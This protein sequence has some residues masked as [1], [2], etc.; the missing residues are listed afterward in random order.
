ME[1]T[2]RI[3]TDVN[4]DKVVEVNLTQDVDTFEILSLKLNQKD[5]Y[6]L[7]SSNYGIVVGR[8]LA[9]GGFGIP[10][11]KISIFVELS[12]EDKMDQV[13][14]TLYPYAS[15]MS[16]DSNGRRYNLLPD[17]STDECYQV[18][19]TFPNKRLVL[20]N[21]DILEV[22]DK[23]WKY[24]TV[25]NHAGDYMIFGVPT[26]SQ[27]LHVDLDMSDI[28]ILSQSPRDFMLRGY[29]RR[30][31]ENPSQF[32]YSTNIDALPQ[33]FSQNQSIHVYPFWGDETEDVIAITR[34]DIEIDYT[35]ETSCVFM[36][37]VLTD[38]TKNDIGDK[39]SPSK[40]AGENRQLVAATGT[41]EMIRKTIGGH[42]EQIQVQ[43]DD[44]IDE[45]GV[46][47]YQI[48]MNLD[49]VMT[50]E[51]GSLVP[52]DNPNIGIATRASVRFRFT[53]DAVEDDGISRHR[54]RYLV[55]NN[56]EIIPNKEIPMIENPSELDDYYKFGQD[57]PDN[58]FRDLYW[59]KVYTVKNYI[60]RIQNNRKVNTSNYSALRLTN[61]SEDRNPIPF[62]KLR[63]N[64]SFR[65]RVI[66]AIM[67]IVIKAVGFLNKVLSKMDKIRLVRV[68]KCV[69]LTDGF[70]ESFDDGR[71][72]TYIPGCDCDRSIGRRT[73]CA[74]DD[75]TKN[76]STDDLLDSI[77]QRLAEEYELANL[78]FYNDWLNGS[79]YMPLWFWKRKKHYTYLFGLFG[80]HS[81]DRFC[82]CNNR[83]GKLRVMFPCGLPLDR[84]MRYNGDLKEG[85]YHNDSKYTTQLFIYH[86]II[87]EVEN[88]DGVKFYYYTHGNIRN[89]QPN[90]SVKT[91][92]QFVR[93][94]ATDIVLLG[95]LNSCDLDGIPQM[96]RALP[97]STAN[98]PPI[99][100]IFEEI[101]P[102][103]PDEAGNS[104]GDVDPKQMIPPEEGIVHETG[105]DWT[106][107]SE[108][109]DDPSGIAYVKGTIFDLACSHANTL[110]KTCVNVERMCELDVSRDEMY[111]FTDRNGDV[112]WSVADGMLT[113]YEIDKND[114]RVMFATLNHYGFNPVDNDGK[115]NQITRE[116][117]VRTGYYHPRFKFLNPQNF[118]GRLS[119]AAPQ[120]TRFAE[121]GKITYDYPDEDYITFRFG[122]D[123]EKHFY[124][125]GGQRK[126]P[127][128]NNSFYFYFGLEPGSTAIDKFNHLFFSPCEQRE[129]RMFT[130]NIEVEKAK[131]C[132]LNSETDYGHISVNLKNVLMPYS[133][134]LIKGGT[135]LL[136]ESGI[137]IETLQFGQHVHEGGM[138]YDN[139]RWGKLQRFTDGTETDYFLT[140]GL[141]TLILTDSA[142]NELV[143]T[144]V[145]EESSVGAAIESQSLGYEYTSGQ[146]Q[147]GICSKSASAYKCGSI[148]LK[149]VII[150]DTNYNIL[151]AEPER[152]ITSATSYSLGLTIDGENTTEQA[153]L[154]LYT[155]DSGGI[156][157]DISEYVCS[158]D[159]AD[160][161]SD[162]VMRFNFWKP[163][164]VNV[165]IMQECDGKWV[166]GTEFASIISIEN[167]KN[168]KALLNDMPYEFLNPSGFTYT[169][170]FQ[171]PKYHDPGWSGYISGDTAE[172]W[173]Q[174]TI[175][176]SGSTYYLDAMK[177]KLKA[178]F[179]M[180]DAGYLSDGASNSF[181]ISAQGGKKPILRRGVYPDYVGM[182]TIL[183]ASDGI[184]W[185]QNSPITSSITPDY[186]ADSVGYAVNDGSLA[187]IVSEEN[188][189]LDLHSFNYPPYFYDN[190]VSIAYRKNNF[191]MDG[192]RFA[193]FTNN[194]G[195]EREGTGCTL[196]AGCEAIPSSADQNPLSDGRGLCFGRVN[197]LP[198]IPYKASNYINTYFVDKRFDYV[199]VVYTPM[200]VREP[201]TA[202]TRGRIYLDI[203][204]GI[205]MAMDESG[206]IIDE[207]SQPTGNSAD[208]EHEYSVSSTSA[209]TVTWNENAKRRYY[210]TTLSLDGSSET[211]NPYD[212]S[213]ALIRGVKPDSSGTVSGGLADIGVSRYSGYNT[214]DTISGSCYLGE[215]TRAGATTGT[216]YWLNT[217]SQT[218]YP[219]R[220][221]LDLIGI[222][223]ASSYTFSNTSFGYDISVESDGN[224][225]YA[226]G[227]PGETVSFSVDNTNPI[228]FG[229]VSVGADGN[230]NF[231]RN[232][233]DFVFSAQTNLVFGSSIQCKFSHIGDDSGSTVSFE[234][235]DDA[236]NTTHNVMTRAP[237]V[238]NLIKDGD[239]KFDA[240]GE[241]KSESPRKIDRTNKYLTGGIQRIYNALGGTAMIVND[242]KTEDLEYVNM[243]D[244]SADG[245]RDP[246]NRYEEVGVELV[247]GDLGFN[248]YWGY[249]C[250]QDVGATSANQQRNIYSSVDDVESAANE[251]FKLKENAI[252]S[253]KLVCISVVR[254]YYHT[255]E[256]L[257]N[258]RLQVWN[259]NGIYDT[260]PFYIKAQTSGENEC[261]A[262]NLIPD[263]NIMFTAENTVA[264]FVFTSGT[265]TISVASDASSEGTNEIKFTLTEP[266][267]ITTS[268]GET[269]GTAV[270]IYLTVNNTIYFISAKF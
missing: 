46:W 238:L 86:G 139:Y 243:N 7:H 83:Y 207:A 111:P 28:G 254:D 73:D 78:D 39:C 63:V 178:L 91:P 45:H 128:Y 90:E 119:N 183:N 6:R 93:L 12:E 171:V 13:I 96:F 36:G 58:C 169:A 24:T 165:R 255:S 38:S 157:S 137:N 117:D 9:N 148:V 1:K 201:S 149:S 44:L 144:I 10:N 59:N 113:R 182:S 121:N 89:P 120:Y 217:P 136:D 92:S 82:S 206:R 53:V 32:K 156:P 81:V 160:V 244:F 34:A 124:P 188:Y 220:K 67:E 50:D 221:A 176:N 145:L 23:Y 122:P 167:G 54:A 4:K 208:S 211:G 21:D 99:A 226:K 129:E 70:F 222:P 245:N 5:L 60:P 51:Y 229:T 16:S 269:S 131:M 107:K 192:N 142:G 77:Q 62:N 116:L 267:K 87:K 88:D 213:E 30:E 43:G 233:K 3:R 205:E 175:L 79:L 180:A 264:S 194:A 185:E 71:N 230:F 135:V 132:C 100:T 235:E 66:C 249:L 2:Y 76:C 270:D 84:N 179:S 29:D 218:G 22:Y 33:I 150:D 35:F 127:L 102:E 41:I 212:I 250:P 195:L 133:Y 193:V 181:Y 258:R 168:F 241:W 223:Y 42:V 219:T 8:V 18:V 110:P 68:E 189:N 75:C 141:Y 72:V 227:V 173:G 123:E 209:L 106:S 203:F 251:Y 174:Y 247:A 263:S 114:P 253:N 155:M 204:N 215:Y 118:D 239:S 170:H 214:G 154:K 162:G 15:P 126:F 74:E 26:G 37:A 101:E 11:A 187:N 265:T 177:Y 80:H 69:Q 143:N 147:T 186:I 158:T 246:N 140:N 47:C 260:R 146:G 190:G 52:T 163:C 259:F 27:I 198:T 159:V 266:I 109:E 25:S 65:Y 64:I 232:S 48:P 130:L 108:P 104:D 257:I 49:Y 55:P 138:A 236:V 184:I 115:P 242:L 85:K 196:V 20:D 268:S 103:A 161:F 252:S 199:G 112:D 231:K 40:T 152:Q 248:Y 151:S 256:D 31:F 98:I 164:E 95:S 97:P 153:L 240:F 202:V 94:Y 197:G 172:K 234:I 166:S 134:K 225:V 262:F 14:R 237:R 200:N 210:K 57:T 19:G 261:Y 61:Y 216:T 105:M 56:P 191:V 17:A 224:G 228:R 125:D